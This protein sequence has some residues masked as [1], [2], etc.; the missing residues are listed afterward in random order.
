MAGVLCVQ[1]KSIIGNNEINFRKIEHFI[2]HNSKKDLDL[3][4]L[5]ELFATNNDYSNIKNND[6]EK[7]LEFISQI[8]K[9]YH[10]NIIAGSILREKNNNIYNTAFAIN[11]EGKILEE[12]D[13]I[14]L[15]NYF[16]NLEEQVSKGE[17]IKIVDFDFARVGIA[18]GFDLRF[19]LH[20][21]KLIKQNVDIITIPSAWY[22]PKEVA[23]D[24]YSMT[25]AQNMWQSLCQT[26]L[27]LKHHK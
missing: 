5:P 4:V 7:T 1:I 14:H 15:N 8:A 20:F 27:F 13:K 9:K 24:K 11:R 12:Y 18:I 10:T 3:V 19:P 17:N 6:V 2:K 23:E 21:N 26:S 22:V 16:T 25:I